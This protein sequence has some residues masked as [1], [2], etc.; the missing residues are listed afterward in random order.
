[1][2]CTLKELLG[3]AKEH[4]FAVGAFNTSDLVLVRAVLEQAE[5]SDAPV[6]LQFAPGE[7]N[8]ATPDFFTFVR[9]R[10]EKS[11]VPVAIHLDHGK[12]I[13]D[14]AAAIKAGF[15]SVMID[16]SLLPYEENVRLTQ[17]VV[18]LAHLMGVSVEG[19]IGTIGTMGNSDEGGV[20]NVV[21]TDPDDVT[22]F[23]GKTGVDA[24][25]IA[26]GTAH[27]IYPKDFVPQLQ[28][29]LLERIAAIAPVPLVLHGGSD[30]PDAEIARA[31]QLGIQKVNISSDIKQVYFQTAMGIYGDTGNFM[32]PQ[33]FGPTIKVVRETVLEKMELFGSVGKASLWR[34][35]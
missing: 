12:T 8:F 30:N 2:L 18:H 24:L 22:D 10:A 35:A 14:C 29:D 34:A 19:E 1:M 3:K 21:Y 6:I 9:A 7:F 13:E 31:C 32:P 25:A 16:G 11:P 17:E 20:E 4:S 26:I 15:T 27:G 28:L 33:V 23:V 5:E